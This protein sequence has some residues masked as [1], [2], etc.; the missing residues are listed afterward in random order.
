MRTALMLLL[1]CSGCHAGRVAVEVQTLVWSARV[2]IEDF[3]FE[4]KAKEQNREEA[5]TYRFV[6]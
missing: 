1:L 4:P 5:C 3:H 2:V 6:D